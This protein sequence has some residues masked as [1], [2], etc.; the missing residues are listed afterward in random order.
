MMTQ[1]LDLLIQLMIAHFP[2]TTPTKKITVNHHSAM[3]MTQCLD[4]LIQFMIAHFP[5]TPSKKI[6]V[7]HHSAMMM[8]QCLDLLI[9]FMIA[10]FPATPSLHTC[11]LLLFVIHNQSV[12]GCISWMRKHNLPMYRAVMHFDLLNLSKAVDSLSLSVRKCNFCRPTMCLHSLPALTVH[13]STS[14]DLLDLSLSA[15]AHCRAVLSF[16]NPY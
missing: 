7:N 15:L 12:V 4:L 1:C 3:M 16:L 6:T 10:H 9:H 11:P 2:V 8:T 14:T 13:L 5:V